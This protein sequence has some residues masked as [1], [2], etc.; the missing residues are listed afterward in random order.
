MSRPH[1]DPVTLGSPQFRSATAGAFLVTEARFPGRLNLPRHLHERTVLGVT[2]GGEFDSVMMGCT[3]TCRPGTV[4]TEPAGER[5][6]N[7]FQPGGTR[8]LILQ[9][10]PACHELLAPAASLLDRINHFMSGAVTA[11]GRRLAAELRHEDLWTPLA[12]EGL[13]LELLAESARIRD[14]PGG[15]GRPPAWLIRAYERAHDS[16]PRTLCMADLAMEAGVHPVHLARMFRR[17]YGVS[18]GAVARRARLDWARDHLVRSDRSISAI[19]AEGGFADQSHF[20]R[21][22]RDAYGCTPAAFRRAQARS[23]PAPL[24]PC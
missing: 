14:R 17:Y 16:A 20:T 18:A 12:I 21:L 23:R 3:Y 22:F 2:L 9:P 11:L 5:H 13:A 1:F 10:D 15:G 8:I 6:A 19:A 24:P 4:H 7:H